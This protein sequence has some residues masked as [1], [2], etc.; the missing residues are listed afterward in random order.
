MISSSLLVFFTAFVI[1]FLLTPLVRRLSLKMGWLDKPNWRKINKKPMPLLGGLAI[2][3]GFSVSILLIIFKEPFTANLTKF[4]GLLGGSFI[5]LLVGIA[6]DIYGFSA[7]KKLFYQIIASVII[8]LSGYTIIKITNPAGGVF[9]IPGIIGICLTIF[10]IVGFTNAINLMD[11]LD[12]LAS[13]VS[14]IIAASLLFAGIKNGNSTVIIL[15]IGIA[16]SALG[17]LPYNF[18]PAKIFMGDTG[19][20]FLGF[21]ISIISI[22]GTYKGTAFMTAVVPIVAMGI[23]VLDTGLAILRRIING[24]GVFKADKEHIHHKMLDQESS[25]KNAV[26]KLYLLTICF[27]LIAA[28]LSGM[29]GIW[30]LFGII[31]TF[32]ATLRLIRRL[33]LVDFLNNGRENA[34][35]ELH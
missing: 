28:G 15:S 29:K 24:N 35:T 27:G 34:K 8:V 33:G 22:E 19:S 21:L 6:D 31:V 9:N 1:S 3:L 13:G 18:Y 25:H 5:I 11:G 12:G 16:G 7:R 14:A 2:Y 23:P 4:L 10:W 17:F 32:F 20:M 26:L 30:A